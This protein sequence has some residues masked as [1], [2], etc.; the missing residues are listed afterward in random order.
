MNSDRNK[1]L[2]GNQN[3][4]V[5][6]RH[7]WMLYCAFGRR[8]DLLRLVEY[9]RRRHLT[10]PGKRYTQLL[11]DEEIRLGICRR[12]SPRLVAMAR[13]L[14]RLNKLIFPTPRHFSTRTA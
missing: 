9:C 8:Q 10:G 13:L 14:Y 3:W 5:V 1:L 4:R 12:Y 7:M 2:Y 11:A 6:L